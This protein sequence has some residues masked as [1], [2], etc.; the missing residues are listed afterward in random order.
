MA[1]G[2]LTRARASKYGRR[3][4]SKTPSKRAA[5]G[6][7]GKRLPTGFLRKKTIEELAA[8]QGVRLDG[9]LERIWGSGAH[10]WE[11]DEEFERFLQDIYDRR[12]E[13]RELSKR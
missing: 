11:S 12:R 13:D 9:Q 7:N 3:S 6:R 1:K 8:E 5:T 4:K 2:T 10:L